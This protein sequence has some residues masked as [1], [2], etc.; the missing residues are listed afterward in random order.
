MDFTLMYIAILNEYVDAIATVW[1]GGSYIYAGIKYKNTISWWCS[2]I[3]W[4]CSN[5]YFIWWTTLTAANCVA[6]SHRHGI[7]CHVLN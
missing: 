7:S 4:W 3:D 6:W 1:P 5:I 2:S